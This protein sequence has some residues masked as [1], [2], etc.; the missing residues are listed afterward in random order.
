MWLP[1]KCNF[2]RN[3]TSREKYLLGKSELPGIVTSVRKV[4]YY[5]DIWT[6]VQVTLVTSVNTGPYVTRHSTNTNHLSNLAAGPLDEYHLVM[7]VLA[8]PLPPVWM[9]FMDG[10]L[11]CC[12]ERASH[13]V[14]T[15][16]GGL[17][18]STHGKGEYVARN[19]VSNIARRQL[20]KNEYI[21]S[22]QYIICN[23]P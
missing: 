10:P 8:F 1:G 12:R 23:V 16:L 3:I 15:K 18:L 6:W 19:F 2:L 9:Y 4:W 21:R 22:C 20:D 7:S 17:P 11:C 13:A 14:M 5:A